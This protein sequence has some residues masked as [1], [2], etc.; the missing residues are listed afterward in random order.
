MTIVA[1]VFAAVAEDE[2]LM[3][4]RLLTLLVLRRAW[5]GGVVAEDVVLRL[6][7]EGAFAAE[8]AAWKQSCHCLSEEVPPLTAVVWRL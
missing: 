2:A 7:F 5:S 3:L 4:W 8:D 1:E 6:L